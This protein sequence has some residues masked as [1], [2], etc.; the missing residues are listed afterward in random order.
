MRKIG[1]ATGVFDMFHIGH[2]NLLRRASLECDYLMVGVT[3]DELVQ[4]LKNKRPIIPFDERLEIVQNI[5]CVNEVIAETSSDKMQAWENI[6]FDVTFKG[7]DWKGTEKWNELERKFKQVGV[8]VLYLPYTNH[9][10]SS[11]LRELIDI[12]IKEN[13]DNGANK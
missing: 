1:Y 12:M 5:K 9:T 11:K 13:S 2:L 4:E 10:S 6:K 3:T 8:E 7:D